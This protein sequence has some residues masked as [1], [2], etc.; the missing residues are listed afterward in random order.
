MIILLGIVFFLVGFLMLCLILLQEG[1]GGGLAAMGGAAT[2]S[3]MGASNPLR[4]WTTY[5][6]IAF[7]ALS[8]AINYAYKRSRQATFTA[9]IET[10]ADELVGSTRADDPDA[11]SEPVLDLEGIVPELPEEGADDPADVEGEAD[12]GD[13]DADAD[14][15]ADADADTDTD[16]DTDTDADAD[17]TDE[18]ELMDLNGEPE[19]A[20]EG[21]D[22][23]V[24]EDGDD[25]E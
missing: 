12:A 9:P 17:A 14:V 3:V 1:K 21:T 10:M 20:P 19:D 4:R 15:D 5:F 7:V 18:E 8:L 23:E 22:A 16:V 11:V 24:T 6:F 2:D 13:A 25:T